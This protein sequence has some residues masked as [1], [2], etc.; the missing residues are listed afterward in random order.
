MSGHS[1]WHSIK[2]K[3][4]A[5]DAKRG[6]L[7]AKLIRSIEVAARDGGGDP[8]ANP[9]LATAV[10]K[11]KDSSMPN[12]TIQRAIKRG[13]GGIDGTAYEEISYEGYAPGGVALFV[14]VL[15]DNRNR[16]AA[17]V[18]STF[19]RHG[20]SLGEPG[21][22]AWKFEKKGVIIVPA[23][24]EDAILEVALEAGAEDV[25]TEDSGFEIRTSASDLGSV[26]AALGEAGVDFDSAEVTMIPQTTTPVDAG[27]APRVLRL[28]ESLEDLDDVQ[29]VYAD[30]DIPEEV[31]DSLSV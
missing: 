24:D 31:L 22:V 7:F 9:T 25:I 18:R 8:D 20:G 23:G 29:N 28:V 27:T 3:K 21:S 13:T 2:H 12:D 17:D 5:T 16:A 1:K 10:Q 6:K 11:A 15:T 26:R 30:F 14:E 4:A 19:T